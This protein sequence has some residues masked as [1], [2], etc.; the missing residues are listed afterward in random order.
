MIYLTLPVVIF[1]IGYL[2]FGWAVLFSSLTIFSAWWAWHDISKKKAGVNALNERSVTIKNSYFLFLIP[3]VLLF[4]YL[5]GVGEF[6]WCVGDHRV[7]YAIL[8]DLIEYKCVFHANVYGFYLETRHE[9]SL[10]QR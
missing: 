7:R 4:L 8:N 1:F 5:G 6:S 2:K 10:P 9:D 3:L